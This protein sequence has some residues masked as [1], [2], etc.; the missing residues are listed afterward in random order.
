MPV[1]KHVSSLQK[2]P[3]VQLLARG[4]DYVVVHKPAGMIIAQSQGSPQNT[5]LDLLQELISESIQ[6]V[7]RLD[8]VTCGC[9]V[10]A[11]GQAAQ[12]RLG[13]AFRHRQ[14]DKRYLALV[15]GCPRFDKTTIDLRLK[16]VDRPNAKKGPLAYQTVDKRGKQ[17]ITHVSLWQTAQ[18]IAAVEIHPITG[19][20]H[21]IRAHLAAIGHPI[22]GDRLYGSQSFFAP[23]S[24]ALLA[25]ALRFPTSTGKSKSVTSHLPELFVQCTQE[26]G[27]DI[28]QQ[29][30]KT[31]RRFCS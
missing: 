24:I 12:Q 30:S 16:R 22:L 31:T 11:Q 18:S 10:F 9:C 4:T 6:P 8:R 26:H 1:T 15:E 13:Q 27:F 28:R 14:I 2:D 5:L 23:H 19:R 29:F 3:I 25:F 17:A 21:Q 20:M 7:H